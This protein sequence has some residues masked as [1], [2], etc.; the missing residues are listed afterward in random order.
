MGEVDIEIPQFFL[1]PI[2]LQIMKD[3]VT[4]ITGITYDRE[5]IEQWLKSSED[6]AF[7]PITKQVLPRDSDL[8][9]NVMLRRYI[10]AWWTTNAK[11]GIDRIPTP[12]SIAS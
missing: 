7:C 1:C 8:T 2:S 4:T 5:S 12:K 11:Y 3:P 10:Q 6:S 9:P